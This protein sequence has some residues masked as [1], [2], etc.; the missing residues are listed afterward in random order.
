[1]C[2]VD[3]MHA[4]RWIACGSVRGCLERRSRPPRE[5]DQGKE[6]HNSAA[7]IP[8]RRF[9]LRH[10]QVQGGTQHV[11]PLC[12]AYLSSGSAYQLGGESRLMPPVVIRNGGAFSSSSGLSGAIM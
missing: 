7:F 4:F 1:M 8:T 5:E 11:A 6:D 2:T 9:M 3:A 12:V 10:V